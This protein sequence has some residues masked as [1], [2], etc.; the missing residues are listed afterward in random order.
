MLR[1]FEILTQAY[2]DFISEVLVGRLLE[3]H[4]F[5]M[6]ILVCILLNTVLVGLQTNYYMVK[7]SAVESWS[8]SYEH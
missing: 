4:G 3:S 7:H 8:V 1:L 5:R 2:D 6:F